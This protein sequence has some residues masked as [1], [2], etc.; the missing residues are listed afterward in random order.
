MEKLTFENLISRLEKIFDLEQINIIKKSYQY[1]NKKHEGERR[2]TGEDYSSHALNVADILLSINADYQT[3][4]AG[5]LH[6]LL[7]T[8]DTSFEELENEFGSEIANLVNGITK[9]NKIS[10]NNATTDAMITNERKI[11]IG[12]T[13]DVRVIFI[14][15][16]DRLHNMRTLW[17]LPEDR[18]KAKAKETLDILIPIA[19]RLGMNKIKSELEELCLRYLKPDAYFDVVEKL[20][21]TKKERDNLVLQMQQ[22]VVDLLNS[23]GIKHEIKGRAKSIYSIY[24]NCINIKY[25][26]L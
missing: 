18:Q 19:H 11:L 9:I 14:K 15:L 3:I 17:A 24:C 26:I 13:E 6:D 8:T 10:F 21:N 23:H 16:A 1:N 22:N 2:R 20:N 4:A 5:I 25:I 12:L 7:E